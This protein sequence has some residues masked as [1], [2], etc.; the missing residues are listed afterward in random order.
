MYIKVINNE[1]K[2]HVLSLYRNETDPIQLKVLEQRTVA[3]VTSSGESYLGSI[4]F[5]HW[6]TCILTFVVA[7]PMLRHVNAQW[8]R[9]YFSCFVLYL[10]ANL[11]IEYTQE[12]ERVKL[13]RNLSTCHS[14]CT[15]SEAFAF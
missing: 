6:L 9:S 11:E 2:I 12:S 10:L 14:V 5:A 3:I 7:E 1:R 15:T 8:I 4:S 13:S